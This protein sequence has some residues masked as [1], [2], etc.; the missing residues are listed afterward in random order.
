M[1]DQD[2]QELY[3]DLK[4]HSE[5]ILKT[6]IVEPQNKSDDEAPKLLCGVENDDTH[7]DR[8]NGL[9]IDA[10]PPGDNRSEAKDKAPPCKSLIQSGIHQ[11]SDHIH[12]VNKSGE[13]HN[14]AHCNSNNQGHPDW[15]VHQ[16]KV[17]DPPT[18]VLK[19]SEQE[20]TGG[21]LWDIFHREDSEK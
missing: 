20:K 9:Q 6:S 18:P 3:G 10:L 7:K 17:S 19:N 4:S 8:C 14:G 16:N 12:E 1:R 21:A 2:L 11:G 15:R 5:I 13:T